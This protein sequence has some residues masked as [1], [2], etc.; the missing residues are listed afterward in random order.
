MLPKKFF[1]VAGRGESDTSR[2]NSF[3]KALVE[4]DIAQC[5]LVPVSSI[6]PSGATEVKP[7][8]IP[9]GSITFCVLARKDGVQGGKISAG[10]EWAFCKGSYG[11]VAEEDSS[12]NQ[13]QVKEDLR[14]KMAEMAEARKLKITKSD[15]KTI[16]IEKIR[17]KYGTVV[18]ALVYV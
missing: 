12:K 14:D 9:A 10:V 15:S 6:L 13:A 2:L 11:M 3:D 18:V 1:V 7:R 5:N 8:K 4:A 16:S 17:K